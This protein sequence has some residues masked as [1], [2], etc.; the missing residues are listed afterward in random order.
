MLGPIKHRYGPLYPP[1][2]LRLLTTHIVADVGS[3]KSTLLGRGIAFLDFLRGMPVVLLDNGDG[4][5]NFLH[6]FL[7]AP[8]AFREA[9]WQRIRYVPLGGLDDYVVPMPLYYRLG[10]EESSIIAERFVDTIITMNPALQ[11]AQVQGEGAIRDIALPVGIE[12]VQRGWQITELPRLADKI[13]PTL[14]VQLFPFLENRTNRAIYAAD[15]PGIDW[16]E[17]IAKRQIVLLDYRQM[18]RPQFALAWVLDM[19][20]KFMQHRGTYQTPISVIIDELAA[21]K[22]A[23]RIANVAFHERWQNILKNIARH[24]QLWMVLAHQ[25]M[26]QFDEAM[27]DLLLSI[28]TQIIGKT[29]SIETANTLS[30]Q[31]TRVDPYKVKRLREQIRPKLEQNFDGVSV[32]RS[33]FGVQEQMVTHEPVEFSISEQLLAGAY[34]F[35]NLNRLEFRVYGTPWMG[36]EVSIKEVEDVSD[37]HTPGMQQV[38]AAV[39]HKLVERDGRKVTDVLAEIQKRTAPIVVQQPPPKPQQQPIIPMG[40]LME[41][42]EPPGQLQPRKRP[43]IRGKPV[44]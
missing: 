32:T 4:I 28:D 39:R 35:L 21:L 7:R 22:T 43:P 24:H 1:D 14:R 40:V 18:E 44:E 3:G 19:F 11:N 12:L 34:D 10:D 8:K 30:R 42:P 6:K 16:H 15:K 33:L 27:Q 29:N 31:L 36:G 20:L 25:Y 37:L 13:A 2:D 38:L 23:Q 26:G 9:N 17:V 5:D 41:A